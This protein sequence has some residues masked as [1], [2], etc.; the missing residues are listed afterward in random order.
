[1]P[2]SPQPWLGFLCTRQEL[3]VALSYTLEPDQELA[4]AS[5]AM[6]NVVQAPEVPPGPQQLMEFVTV[7][8]GEGERWWV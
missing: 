4:G 7:R 3:W 6:P 8:G 2:P 5:T 1:M